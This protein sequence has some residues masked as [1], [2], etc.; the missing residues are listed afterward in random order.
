MYY[1]LS[2]ATGETVEKEIVDAAPLLNSLKERYLL[3]A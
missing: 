1:V 3:N 2:D